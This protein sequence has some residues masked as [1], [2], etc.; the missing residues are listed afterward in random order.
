V[1]AFSAVGRLSVIH[2]ASARTS[3]RTLWSG[4]FYP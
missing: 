2:S 4:M 3:T 1:I